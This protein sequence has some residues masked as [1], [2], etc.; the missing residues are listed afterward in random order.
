MEKKFFRLT[1]YNVLANLTV[2]LTGLADTAVLGHLDTHVYMAGVALSEIIFDY[3]FWSFGFLRMGTTGLTAQAFG[4]KDEHKSF[5]IF[6]R[7]L[8]LGC[9]I[10]IGILLLQK[11]IQ[12]IS[13]KILHGEI[14]VL[15]AG[16]DYY[17][18]RI[19]S[20]PATLINFVLTGWFL[21]RSK[22]R[23]VLVATIL[24]NLVNIGLNFWFVLY[25]DWRAW[26]AGFATS[27]SQYL[28][29]GFFLCFLF[30][31]KRRIGL[32]RSSL[33]ESIF[34]LSGFGDLLSLNR[35]ILFRTVM[36]ITTFSLFRNFSSEFGSTYLAANAILH[37]LVLVAAYWMDGAAIATETI[38]GDTK[39]KGDFQGL[40][41]LL[42]L[43]LLS[44]GI[45]AFLFCVAL[46]LFPTQ[47]F[48]MITRNVPVLELAISYRLWLWPVLIF[49]SIAFIF[50]GFFLGISDGK[51][52]R[53][54]MII[55]TLVFFLPFALWGKEA[56]SNHILWLSLSSFMFGRALTLGVAAARK[57]R[58]S[59]PLL[60]R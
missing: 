9:G 49:G 6:Y 16:M 33:S 23:T 43:A 21:G 17:E 15:I 58:D 38:A 59:I 3:L 27:I 39:G 31:E 32:K 42:K 51:T 34:S 54:A 40:S 28:M 47:L 2:P 48:S 25:L 18:A 7:S 20:A 44:A 19:L 52:L 5:L 45:I 53:N 56:S 37:Q 14:S 29:T 1:F 30:L 26:G 41:S 46:T 36:L 8:I 10:G 50:D 11:P 4:A 35:D 13:L 57:I 60:Q 12:Q 22:S 24:A 55:S